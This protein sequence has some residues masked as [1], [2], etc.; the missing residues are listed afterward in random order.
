MFLP[1]P[2]STNETTRLTPEHRALSQ[3]RTSLGHVAPNLRGTSRL[4]E[5][6]EGAEFGEFDVT[7]AAGAVETEV[8]GDDDDDDEADTESVKEAAEEGE[9]DADGEVGGD[10]AGRTAGFASRFL[11]D[12]VTGETGGVLAGLR[13]SFDFRVLD[14]EA[15]VDR[16]LGGTAGSSKRL[17]P[18]SSIG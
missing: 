15:E 6:A 5:G 17:S 12:A 18:G 4:A 9:A 8:D 14:A 7:F 3:T 2:Y 16:G 11:V 10:L 13:E 1:A